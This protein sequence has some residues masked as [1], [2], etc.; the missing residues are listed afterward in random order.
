VR[1]RLLNGYGELTELGKKAVKKAA[2]RG[3]KYG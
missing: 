2:K 1:R 3:G